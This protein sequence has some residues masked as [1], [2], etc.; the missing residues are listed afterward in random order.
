MNEEEY[1]QL[2]KEN[3]EKFNELLNEEKRINATLTQE[4]I[5]ARNQ[6]IELKQKINNSSNTEN[7]IIKRPIL[8][9]I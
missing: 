2:L 4:L 3:L 5:Q 1:N 8:K 6:I 7:F 9:Q